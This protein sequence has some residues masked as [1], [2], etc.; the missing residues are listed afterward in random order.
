MSPLDCGA[1]SLWLYSMCGAKSALLPSMHRANLLCMLKG[2]TQAWSRSMQTLRRSLH[3]DIVL[4][5]KHVKNFL[6]LLIKKKNFQPHIFR[7]FCDLCDFLYRQI[8]TGRVSL[9]LQQVFKIPKIQEAYFSFRF[10][11]FAF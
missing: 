7:S 4:R 5:T 6:F 10:L 8:F 3:E 2:A 1:K 9:S 11:A